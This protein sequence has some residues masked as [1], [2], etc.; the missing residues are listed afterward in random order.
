[1]FQTFDSPT[2]PEQGPPRLAKLRGWMAQQELNG[3]IVPRADRHQGE[4]AGHFFNPAGELID[5]ETF[6]AGKSEWLGSE[7][8]RDY[9]KSVMVQVTEP[10]QFANWIAPP[11]RGINGNPVEYQYVQFNGHTRD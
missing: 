7:A 11:R 1:M 9:V 3:F 8:D 10:G 2:A 5:E 6:E 4:Y